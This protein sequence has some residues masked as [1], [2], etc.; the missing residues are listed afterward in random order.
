[1]YLLE[2]FFKVIVKVTFL[3]FLLWVKSREAIQKRL[4]E[5]DGDIPFV[6]YVYSLVRLNFYFLPQLFHQAF[7][8]SLIV[9]RTQNMNST[10][11]TDFSS[12]QHGTANYRLLIRSL[13]LSHLDQMELKSHLLLFG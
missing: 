13:R 9:L 1:M 5:K 3:C 11:S 12:A 6:P 4:M 2:L 7:S 10:L 8:F